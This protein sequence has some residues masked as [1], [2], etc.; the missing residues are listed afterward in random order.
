FLDHPEFQRALGQVRSGAPVVDISG[1]CGSS[2]GLFVAWLHR[3]LHKPVVFL[4]TKNQQAEQHLNDIGFFLSWLG[5]DADAA[6]SFP[7]F[8]VD[9]YRMSPHPEV[10]EQR[11]HTLWRLLTSNVAVLVAPLESVLFRMVAPDDFAQVCKT[12]RVGEDY[13]PETLVRHLRA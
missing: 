4:T 6:L 7:G 13:P 1:L 11:A 3:T 10:A 2:K 12:L 8:E 5:G 9:C